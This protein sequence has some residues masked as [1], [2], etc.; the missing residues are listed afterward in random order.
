MQ[1]TNFQ[2]LHKTTYYDLQTKDMTNV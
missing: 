1:L 2:V